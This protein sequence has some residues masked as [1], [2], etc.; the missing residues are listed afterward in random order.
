MSSPDGPKVTRTEGTPAADDLF[1][2]AK[3]SGRANIGASLQTGNSEKDAINA[4]AELTAKWGDKHRGKILAEYNRENDDGQ[5]TED[6]RFLKGTYDYFFSKKWFA[7]SVISFRQDDID[8]IDLRTTIGAGLGYQP[9]ESDELNLQFVAGPTY[10]R[11]EYEDGDSEDS[12][13]ARWAMD[14]D[15]KL[16]DEAIQ[17]FHK[18]ELLTPADDMESF[19]FDSSSG[20]RVPLKKG[21]IA[22]AQVDFDWDN[23]P[24][25]GV[26]EDDTLYG[27]KLGYEW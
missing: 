20:L 5:I 26:V 2:G 23:A 27:L 18:H 19:L 14:Y 11:T 8:M 17:I 7:N 15:Q 22:T 10:L 21:L 12:I 3:W 24:E 4:D 6:N 25:P 9:Y 16:F 13:A 1:W